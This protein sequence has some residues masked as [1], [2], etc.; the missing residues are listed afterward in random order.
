MP[1]YSPTV[2]VPT[3]TLN[4]AA[5]VCARLGALSA[6]RRSVA[7]SMSRC[8]ATFWPRYHRQTS[9]QT[10]SMSSE[11]GVF[12]QMRNPDSRSLGLQGDSATLTANGKRPT[13]PGEKGT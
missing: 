7:L 4:Q 11:N 10:V 9:R 8:S 3:R 2:A 6:G 1:G 12:L 13:N 5:P